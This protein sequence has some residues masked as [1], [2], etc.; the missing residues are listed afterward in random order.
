MSN[1]EILKTLL[2]KY[3]NNNLLILEKNNENELNDIKYCKENIKN[4]ESKK[5]FNNFYRKFK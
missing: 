4:F 5:Y 3:L 1:K 2:E